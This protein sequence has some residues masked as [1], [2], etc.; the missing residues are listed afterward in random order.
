MRALGGSPRA[1]ARGRLL[2]AMGVSSPVVQPASAGVAPA[3]E[4]LATS[5]DV[6]GLEAVPASGGPVVTQGRPGPPIRRVPLTSGGEVVGELRVGA[7]RTGV[8]LSAND[9]G[10]L[11]L[12]ATYIANAMRTGDREEAQLDSLVDLT[13]DRELVEQQASELHEALVRG[14]TGPVLRV[15]AL[16]PLR[17]ERD[18]ERIDRWGGDKAGT[19]QAEGL[20]AFLLDAGERGVA[21]DEVLEVIGRTPTSPGP[22]S[23]STGR[24]SVCAARWIV[25]AADV[26]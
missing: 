1:L 18:G 9:E 24:W 25:A 2:Q 6:V 16:G 3:L 8:D 12:S 20:F 19:R 22:I 11:R 10:L 4:R 23:R 15:H 13:A 5:L 17:V 21:K 26:P 7:T 14:E